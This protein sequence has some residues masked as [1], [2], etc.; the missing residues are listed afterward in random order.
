MKNKNILALVF[1]LFAALTG[2]SCS[3]G[4]QKPNVILIVID[5]VR[6]DHLSCYGY[7]RQ[8]MPRIDDFAKDAVRFDDAIAAS[9][10]TLPSIASILTGLYPHNHQAGYAGKDPKTNQEGLT[11][12]SQGA[13]TLTEVLFQNQYQTVGIFQS[14]FMDPGLGLN[15]GFEVY[16]WE[17]GDNMQTRSASEVSD[18]AMEWLDK[19][20]N[21]SQP[22]FLVLHYFDPH[23]AYAPPPDLALPF[24]LKYQGKMKPPF[25]PSEPELE[26]IQKGQIKFSKEDQSFIEGLYNG[27]LNY[28]D[29]AI[30]RFFDYLKF[31]NLYDQ[32]LIILTSDH[33]EEF[34][35][36][37]S[38]E[39]GHSLYQ[40]LLQVP[41]IVRLPGG[42]NKG[43]VIKE[44]VS[45]VDIAGSVLACLRI[46]SLLRPNGKSFISMPG[47][48][49]KPMASRAIIA[50]LN[51][52]GDPLQALYRNEYKLILNRTTAKIQVYNLAVDP[53]E[54]N[55]LF[56]KKEAF[57]PEMVDQFKGVAAG[58]A[59]QESEKKPLPAKLD[60]NTIQKLKAL[61]YLK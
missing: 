34:W 18:L 9:P 17:P 50:E 36:H 6:K 16:N 48:V 23:L 11:Y 28:V 4:K 42:E 29:F 60:P 27:E 37:N 25:N 1:A 24:T 8:T 3:R 15:R 13:I 57:P 33:G 52:I 54:K 51:R 32:S 21:K 2:W 14:P 46:E 19:T 53:Q 49:V 38:F 45:Q 61:G 7:N 58:I 10:W 44:R 26:K 43:L 12:L 47:A 22:F 59:K 56:G 41:L 5:T 20:R 30:G 31:A 40:E 35:D 55:N 39:H